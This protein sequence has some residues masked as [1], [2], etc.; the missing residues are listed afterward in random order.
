MSTESLNHLLIES[1]KCQQF[2]LAKILIDKGADYQTNYHIV[3]KVATRCNNFDLVRY[4]LSLGEDPF[5]DNNCVLRYA[6]RYG[7]LDLIKSLISQNNELL[8]VLKSEG[9][10]YAIDNND[11]YIHNYGLHNMIPYQL[12]NLEAVKYLIEIRCDIVNEIFNTYVESCAY[13]CLDIFKY[14][15]SLNNDY[16]LH[17]DQCM[18]SACEYNSIDI[19]EYLIS[20]NMDLNKQYIGKYLIIEACKKNNLD[21]IKILVSNG[22]NVKINNNQVRRVAKQYCNNEVT[23]YL[24]EQCKKNEYIDDIVSYWVTNIRFYDIINHICNV[25]AID[26]LEKSDLQIVIKK[27]FKSIINES[28][29]G[30]INWSYQ[31][32]K[33]IR[34]KTGEMFK[35]YAY[36]LNMR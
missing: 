32:D 2:D 16:E 34:R 24:F 15:I 20:L 26:K 31:L 30:E 10:M 14:L 36:Y 4:L 18:L 33:A 29:L 35:K 6:C 25:Y 19:V 7:H 28:Y 23:Q 22:A 27:M 1:I 12:P 11:I 5:I 8:S 21:I 3:I 17:L 13:N 9:L